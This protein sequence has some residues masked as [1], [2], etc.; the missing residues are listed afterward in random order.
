MKAI[1]IKKDN[2]YIV[3]VLSYYIQK[4]LKNGQLPSTITKELEDMQVEKE[5]ISK[6]FNKLSCKKTFLS[7][8]PRRIKDEE[9]VSPLSDFLEYIL[10]QDKLDKEYIYLSVLK[11][12]WSKEE[13]LLALKLLKYDLSLFNDIFKKKDK[14]E[15]ILSKKVNKKNVKKTI[16][17]ESKS[18]KKK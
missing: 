8:C 4:A 1:K 5:I 6:S 17:K 2:E 18:K 11:K 7:L 14:K 3:V 13:F 9:L 15:S 12:G 16:K 10:S